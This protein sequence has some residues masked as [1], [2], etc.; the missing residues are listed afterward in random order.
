MLLL[1][2]RGQTELFMK[3]WPAI[4]EALGFQEGTSRY[5]RSFCSSLCSGDLTQLWTSASYESRLDPMTSSRVQCLKLKSWDLFVHL[6]SGVE[7]GRSG[8]RRWYLNLFCA[9]IDWSESG[10]MPGTRES[11]ARVFTWKLAWTFSAPDFHNH[12]LLMEMR[13]HCK[14]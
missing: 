4:V 13:C 11:T 2:S 9:E 8:G 6:L 14:G 7:G 3:S 12:Q 10:F 1:H 5:P